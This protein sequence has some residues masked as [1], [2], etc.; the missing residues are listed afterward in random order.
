MDGTDYTGLSV[1]SATMIPGD[2]STH[3]FTLTVTF[4]NGRTYT[5]APKFVAA[6]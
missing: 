4:S 2:T 3:G 5:S 1:P 6:T